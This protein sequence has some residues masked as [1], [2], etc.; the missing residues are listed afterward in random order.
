MQGSGTPA[1]GTMDEVEEHIAVQSDLVRHHS[2]ISIASCS[3]C[4]RSM[5]SSQAQQ[6]SMFGGRAKHLHAYFVLEEAPKQMAKGP[7]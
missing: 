2:Q 6:T 3:L 7:G 4:R 1:A 5:V